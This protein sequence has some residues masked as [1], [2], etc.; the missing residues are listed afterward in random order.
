MREERRFILSQSLWLLY[1]FTLSPL[2]AL[3][4]PG[5]IVRGEQSPD[6][7]GVSESKPEASLME[8][9]IVGIN[10]MAFDIL[11]NLLKIRLMKNF[12]TSPALDDRAFCGTAVQSI[13]LKENQLT[14]VPDVT[15]LA[16]TLT[17]LTLT[18]NQ[19][20]RIPDGRLNPLRKLNLLRLNENN[21]TDI[22][23][24]TLCETAIGVLNLADNR[25]TSF[26]EVACI[27]NY[28]WKLFLHNNHICVICKEHVQNLTA[29]EYL[30]L[31]N[32]CL[33]DVGE[34]LL[35]VAN[36]GLETLKLSLNRISRGIEHL[37]NLQSLK[38]LYL[39]SN[40]LQ[41]VYWVRR[42]ARYIC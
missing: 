40:L 31:D 34:L 8:E 42:T 1:M 27:G 39:S 28:L 23:D 24:G 5:V 3:E 25:I 11:P 17:N 41:C 7:E 21:L 19:I 16:Q 15:C 33:T 4:L 10:S 18:G 6:F 38:K 26:P 36:P 22:A 30:S 32:N 12:I 35:Y 14:V 29:L 9:S 2:S 20:V 13:N 37:G